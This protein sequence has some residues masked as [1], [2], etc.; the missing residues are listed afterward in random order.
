MTIKSSEFVQYAFKFATF[1]SFLGKL[2]FTEPKKVDILRSQ[3]NMQKPPVVKQLIR[4]G[5]EVIHE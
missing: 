3:S 2:L 1:Y 5:K 4:I